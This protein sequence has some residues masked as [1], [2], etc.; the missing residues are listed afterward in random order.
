MTTSH[1][2]GAGFK[3]YV[4]RASRPGARVNSINLGTSTSERGTRILYV[5]IDIWLVL[6][7]T[8]ISLK[9]SRDPGNHSWNVVRSISAS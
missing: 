5:D 9:I 3:L 4:S 2:P 1:Q 6:A 7:L 8:L